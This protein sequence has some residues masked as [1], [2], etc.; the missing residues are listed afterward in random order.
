MNAEDKRLLASL[1]LSSRIPLHREFMHKLVADTTLLRR[2]RATKLDEAFID[3]MAAF[4]RVRGILTRRFYRDYRPRPDHNEI[5]WWA[6]AN[7]ERALDKEILDE[8]LLSSTGKLLL[9]GAHAKV[10]LERA[11]IPT[12]PPR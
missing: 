1:P 4:P 11:G 12:L 10:L 9:A 6:A 3:L 8:A 7:L 5:I 2:L